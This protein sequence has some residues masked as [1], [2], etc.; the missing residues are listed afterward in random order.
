VDKNATSEACDTFY[1]PE[2]SN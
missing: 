2:S 1:N